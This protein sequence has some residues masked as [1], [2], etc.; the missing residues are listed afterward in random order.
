M[1]PVNVFMHFLA[2]YVASHRPGGS[3]AAGAGEDQVDGLECEP[4]A[5][6]IG[7]EGVR[8]VSEEEFASLVKTMRWMD[9]VCAVCG[10]E[11]GDEVCPDT[12]RDP[13]EEWQRQRSFE[14]EL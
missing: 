12:L 6:A 1:V 14:W 13:E 4:V 3:L 11:H 10:R 8:P 5:A 9:F 7:R 2:L